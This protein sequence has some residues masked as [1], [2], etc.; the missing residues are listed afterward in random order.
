MLWDLSWFYLKWWYYSANKLTNKLK[1]LTYSIAEI[2]TL[3]GLLNAAT[4]LIAEIKNRLDRMIFQWTS[5]K[6]SDFWNSIVTIV[7]LLL[8]RFYVRERHW[9]Q[10][11]A[12][13]TRRSVFEKTNCVS[14]DNKTLVL[15][16][17]AKWIVPGR[18]R[19]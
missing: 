7:N 14:T 5:E 2:K 1:C 16:Y 18:K 11:D 6:T 10:F 9:F 17:Q 12:M 3:Y 13:T 19:W 15:K 8:L 4:F